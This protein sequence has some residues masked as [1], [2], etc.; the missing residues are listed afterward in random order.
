MPSIWEP[1][2]FGIATPLRKVIRCR[3]IVE[4]KALREGNTSQGRGGISMGLLGPHHEL[5]LESIAAGTLG[6]LFRLLTLRGS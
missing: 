3:A 1:A 6:A 4:F 2:Q 5:L